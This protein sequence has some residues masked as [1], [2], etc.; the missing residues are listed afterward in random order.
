MAKAFVSYH[1]LCNC[2]I[3]ELSN[4]FC[5]FSQRQ[6][7]KNWVKVCFISIVN[8]DTKSWLTWWCNLR[9]NTSKAVTIEDY[10]RR[11]LPLHGYRGEALSSMRQVSSLVQISSQT[12]N[13]DT[14][15][16]LFVKGKRHPVQKALK[17][18]GVK[19]TTVIVK[20][21]YYTLPVRY[22]DI[23]HEVKK[24][25]NFSNYKREQKWKVC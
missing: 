1:I 6:F 16:S 9:Y 4:G 3:L 21:F 5:H 25:W 8:Y 23:T 12:A 18:R 13:N 15:I 14:Y 10:Q 7:E 11:N 19:G 22:F 17:S 2:N 20:D 24:V